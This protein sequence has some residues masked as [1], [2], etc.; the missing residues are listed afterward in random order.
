MDVIVPAILPKSRDDL[1]RKLSL[2]QGH[3]QSVQIDIV[4]GRFVSPPSWPYCEG[5][6]YF[7]TPEEGHEPDMLPF[8]GRMHYEMDLMVD[9]PQEVTGTWIAAGAERI[10]IHAESTKYLPKA[11]QDLE[12]R[13]GHAKDFAPDLLSLGLAIN[14]G[15][16]ISLIEPYLDQADFV[17]FMGIAIIGKQG[18]P[19]DPRVIRKIA[20]FK[21]KYPEMTIQVDGGV[22]LATAP[23]LLTAGVDRLIVGSGLW[24]AQN[25]P[26]ELDKFQQLVQEYG[27]YS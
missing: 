11:I 10:I 26:E 8:L 7:S 24:K 2:L 20:A 21:K 27:I 1:E 15:T 19:F 5:T 25:I 16:E 14:I 22:S 4:D 12:T 18:E 3:V 13:Y 9:D 17:Q 6:P 23:A